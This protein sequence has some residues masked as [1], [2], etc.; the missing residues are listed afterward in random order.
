MINSKRLFQAI[1]GIFLLASL[2]AGC[3]TTQTA[4]NAGTS[5]GGS[6]PQGKKQLQVALV[7][8][9]LSNPFF[10]AMEEGAKKA[11]SEFGIKLYAQAAQEETSVE[12]Q[13]AIVEDMIAKKMD[14]IVIAPSASKEIVPVL[15][16]AQDAGITVVNIDNQVDP[17]TA[18]AA[19]L[20]VPYVGASNLDGGY[21]AGKY[22]AEQLNGK[23]KVA[24]IE[25][26]QGVDNAENRK[27]GAMKAFSEYSG[28][29]VVASQSAN[30]KTEEALNV[31]TNILQAN[32]E[33]DGV[34]AAND[35]MAFGAVQAIAAV[36][37]TDRIKVA[38][39]DALDQAKQYI[40]EGKMIST[41]DQ[42]PDEMGYY[43]VKYALD[44][45]NGKEVQDE[46]MVE[47]INITKENVK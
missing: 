6:Q 28:I 29:E 7:M 5:E 21:M 27:A 36:G 20:R 47:L 13:I 2:A 40:K 35:M 30:W 42:R 43:G 32:P 15:K 24:I 25:G 16:K 8:K 33:L 41:I 9:T 31:M 38:A 23:G 14:A 4:P 22:L 10:I 12:Q 17:E 37:K 39:Y 45:I 1:A 44:L 34:F 18:K 26:I 11:E 19:G 3:S 46:Y